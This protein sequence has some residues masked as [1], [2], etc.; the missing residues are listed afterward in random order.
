MCAR[1]C[2]GV[3][4]DEYVYSGFAVW[5]GVVGLSGYCVGFVNEHEESVEFSFAVR[6]GA[7]HV[8]TSFLSSARCFRCM[9]R[10]DLDFVGYSFLGIV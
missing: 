4:G 7:L 9:C 3:F 1:E 5:T 2:E 8:C 10:G 6:I